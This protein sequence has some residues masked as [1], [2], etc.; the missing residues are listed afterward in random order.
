MEFKIEK[1]IKAVRRQGSET[2]DAILPLKQME[3]GDSIFV[4]ESFLPGNT[5]QNKL[6][7]YK[8]ATGEKFSYSK[9]IENEIKGARI[10]KI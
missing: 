9:R 3:V 2:L 6:T 1:G 7:V 5:I 10:W 8:K 4:P